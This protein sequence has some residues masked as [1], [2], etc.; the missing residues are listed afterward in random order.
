[1]DMGY[2]PHDFSSPGKPEI[3]KTENNLMKKS[4]IENA[5]FNT[6]HLIGFRQI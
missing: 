4:I 1:M 3:G 2:V 5:K 6:E